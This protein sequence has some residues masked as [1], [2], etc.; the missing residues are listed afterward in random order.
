MREVQ[1]F[2]AVSVVIFAVGTLPGNTDILPSPPKGWNKKSLFQHRSHL[3][4]QKEAFGSFHP[5]G[6]GGG[7]GGKP[8]LLMDYEQFHGSAGIKSPKKQRQSRKHSRRTF[9]YV[10]HEKQPASRRGASPPPRCIH[11]LS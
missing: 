11:A 9:M 8:H 7:G 4:K 10:L 6:E 1:V 2:I 5:L 3:K